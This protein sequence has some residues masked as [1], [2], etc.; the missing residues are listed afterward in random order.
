M[1]SVPT[2]ADFTVAQA[3]GTLAASDSNPHAKLLLAGATSEQLLAFRVRATNDDIK[4]RDLVFTG[5]NLGS[6]SN[7]KITDV[8]GSVVANSATTT[9]ST[10][11]TFKNLTVSDVISKD[12]TKTYYVTA[13][14]NLN[15]SANGIVLKLFSSGSTVKSSNGTIVDMTGATS[16]LSNTD[17]V[18]ENMAIVAKTTNTKDLATSALRFSVTATGNNTATLSGITVK[19]SISGYT[20]TTEIAIYKDSVSDANLVGTGTYTNNTAT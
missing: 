7:F 8:N 11:V 1:S 20:G 19:P 9:T 4:L 15:T 12:S 13:D 16:V 5:S 17:R 3:V 2:S 6:L 14:T 10:G 18:E